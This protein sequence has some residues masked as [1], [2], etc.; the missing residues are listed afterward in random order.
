MYDTKI[1]YQE[2]KIEINSGINYTYPHI[3]IYLL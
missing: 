2:I 3:N 1:N